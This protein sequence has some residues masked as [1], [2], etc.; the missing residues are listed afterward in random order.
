MMYLMV[1]VHMEEEHHD[2]EDHDE[3]EED[4]DE[5]EENPGF[6]ANS[7]F[8]SESMKFGA[9]VVVRMGLLGFLYQ[10]LKAHMVFLFMEKA[11]KAM[12]R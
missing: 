9:S 7:D 5:H 4:H 8:A 2:E 11:M 6:L 1:Q 12:V 3:H 10:V